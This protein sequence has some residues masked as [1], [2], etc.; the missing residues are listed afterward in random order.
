MS[1]PDSQ[2]VVTMEDIRNTLFCARAARPWF[3]KNNINF[4]DFLDSKVTAAMLLATHDALA[5]QVVETA[6][7]RVE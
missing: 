2:I 5:V 1:I 6:R 3:R 7:K 4:D